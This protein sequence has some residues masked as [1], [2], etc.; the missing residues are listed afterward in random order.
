VVAECDDRRAERLGAT[1]GTIV[2][3]EPT[4]YRAFAGAT[5]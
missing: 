2:F 3:I 4:R 5:A 1:R